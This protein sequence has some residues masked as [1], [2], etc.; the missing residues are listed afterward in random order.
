MWWHEEKVPPQF[1]D[2]RMEIIWIAIQ[3]I[4]YVSCRLFE[5]QRSVLQ[6][7]ER[8]Q[9][10]RNIL[11][12]LHFH[13]CNTI[14]L[15]VM[16]IDDIPQV[17]CSVRPRAREYVKSVILEIYGPS[18]NV[19]LPQKLSLAKLR[20]YS[21]IVVGVI[22]MYYS[23]IHRVS[24]GPYPGVDGEGMRMSN[25][26]AQTLCFFVLSARPSRTAIHVPA[27]CVL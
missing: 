1:D 23:K 4:A 24:Q 6:R 3:K 17:E 10:W 16:M 18:G 9:R 21:V 25:F 20:K 11:Q 19:F 22:K 8:V 26:L 12:S 14:D 7:C 15:L 27:R 13:L 5:W 2:F